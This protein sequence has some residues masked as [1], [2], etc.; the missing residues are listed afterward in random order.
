MFQYLLKI[1]TPHFTMHLTAM[2]NTN[3]LRLN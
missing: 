3:L 2:V 1:I